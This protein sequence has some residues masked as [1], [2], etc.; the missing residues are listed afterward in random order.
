MSPEFDP[1]A[2]ADIL[3]AAWRHGALLQ[4]LP[5][6][7]RPVTMAQGYAVQDALIARIGPKT[8]G[9]KLGLGS[10]KQ[11]RTLGVGRA[12]AGRI[13]DGALFADGDTIALPNDAP[14]TVEFEIAYVLGRDI[15]PEEPAFPVLEAVAETRVSYELV[16]SRF[17]DR[18]AVGWPSFAADN[19][20]CQA[21]VLGDPITAA[22]IPGI[23]ATLVVSQNGE[24]KVRAL[25]GEDATDPVGSLTDLIAIA[26]E[27]RMV[28]PKG[29]VI[30]SGTVSQPF[31]IIGPA[32]ITASFLGR[33]FGFRTQPAARA[34]SEG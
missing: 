20:G 3:A 16:L 23:V 1:A 22:D 17:I 10:H 19:A 26:R 4:A 7:A 13:L 31:D 29:S 21:I 8:V 33:S 34:A 5:E 30:S 2:A 14:A 12:V 18:R 32:A 11:K 9:W 25:T 27:R 6:P 28:L 24:A 15:M